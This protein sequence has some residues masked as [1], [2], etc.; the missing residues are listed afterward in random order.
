[1]AFQY[2]QNKGKT[3]TKFLALKGSYHGDTFGA[4]SIGAA[5]GFHDHYKKLFFDVD[6][7]ER[8]LPYQSIF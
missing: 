7:L 1:M 4:M 8:D 5:T 2:Q 3:P 6:F